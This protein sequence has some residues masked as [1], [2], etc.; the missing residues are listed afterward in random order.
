MVMSDLKP[1][2]YLNEINKPL[3]R[4]DKYLLYLG[5]DKNIIYER[6]ILYQD[7][8]LS[9]IDLICQT[10]LGDDITNDDDKIKHFD[11][12]WN[13]TAENFKYTGIDFGAN[14]NL[15]EYFSSFAIETFYGAKLKTDKLHYN[16]LKLWNF[17]F[18][19]TIIKSKADIDSFL[20][21]YKIFDESLKK[22]KKKG[23]FS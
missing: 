18:D 21:I 5:L 16:L 4:G 13:K 6:C 8:T 12:C 22:P 23:F 15:Y 11:W 10:Y 14:L 1:S 2:E 3:N 17:L 9:L 19:L 7:F 20:I